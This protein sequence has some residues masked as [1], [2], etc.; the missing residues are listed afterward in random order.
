L[1]RGQ[2]VEPGAEQDAGRGV[3]EHQGTGLDADADELAGEDLRSQQAA[4]S[5]A[6]QAAAG[7]R[8]LHFDRLRACGS[9]AR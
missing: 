6:D 2:R 5:E 1:F 9:P 8:T 4:F 3:V 7:D